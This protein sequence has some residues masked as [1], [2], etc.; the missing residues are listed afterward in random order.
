[1]AGNAALGEESRVER[2]IA[3]VRGLVVNCHFV[4][5][6]ADIDVVLQEVPDNRDALYLAA[7]AQRYLKQPAGA[8]KTLQRLEVSDPFYGRLYQERGHCYRSLGDP[9]TAAEAFE[10][11][12]SLNVALPASWK[13]LVELYTILGRAPDAERARQHVDYLSTL[14]PQLIGAASHLYE[15]HLHKAETLCRQYLSTHGH[16][17]EGMRLLAEIGT[18]F[19]VLDDVEF[20]LESCVVFAPDHQAARQEYVNVLHRRQKYAK[21][22]EHAAILRRQD[23]GNRRVEVLYANQ[24]VALGQYDTA[25]EI[26]DAMLRDVAG[27]PEMHLARGHTLKTLGRQAEAVDAYRRAVS[28]RPGYGEAYWSLANLKTYRLTDTDVGLMRTQEAAA[29]TGTVDR[30]NLCFALGKALED[31]GKYGESFSYYERGN[32]LKKQERRYVADYIERDL[33][34]Q[35]T[36]CGE[37]LFAAKAGSGSARADPIFIVG[38]PR[39]GSTLLEQILASHSQV[40]GTHELPNIVALAHRLDRRRRIDEDPSYPASLLDVSPEQLTRFGELYIEETSVYRT[41]KPFFVDKMPNNFRHIGLIHLMLPNARIIDARREPMA[42]CFSAF[43]QLFIEGQE[44]T[45][46]LEDVGRYYRNYVELMAHWDGVLPGRVLRIQYEDVVADLE[47]N[48]R[49]VLEYCG[50]E[51]EPACVDFH[52]TLRSV[53]TASSEQVRLPL[54]R[55][56]LDQWRRYEPYLE[57]LKLALGDLVGNSTS[58]PLAVRFSPE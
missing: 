15:G 10:R 37:E 36:T 7:V 48:V 27:D 20:L 35:A 18:R 40:E 31:A 4:Q 54:F 52:R 50:L 17:V 30:Y 16:H 28:D 12:V 22:H 2:A 32:A 14:P 45:Y 47:S 57:P 44:F 11:A 19:N 21:A 23:P 42:C 13:S 25:L 41:G 26:Y 3:T 53:R 51:F 8:L 33:H 5:A 6:L 29:T 34:V 55:E 1:M 49:K 58:G 43:K 9:A 46:G 24:C 38:L 39:A 56:G